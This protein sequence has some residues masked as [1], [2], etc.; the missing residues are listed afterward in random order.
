MVSPRGQQQLSLADLPALVAVN[1]LSRI[2]QLLEREHAVRGS[3]WA[4]EA[5]ANGTVNLCIRGASG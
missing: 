2:R 4:N 3:T 5:N 1:D